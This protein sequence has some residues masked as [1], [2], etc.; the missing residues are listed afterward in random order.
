M[1]QVRQDS[2]ILPMLRRKQPQA[3]EGTQARQGP[4]DSS[5]GPI[6]S[7]HGPGEA[8]ISIMACGLAHLDGQRGMLQTSD[9][10][11]RRAGIRRTMRN[12]RVMCHQRA[13]K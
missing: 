8:K 10:G 12:R 1:P 7:G 9:V 5:E 2:T 11:G 6:D 13:Q 3:G 4:A